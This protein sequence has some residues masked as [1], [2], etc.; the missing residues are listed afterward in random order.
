VQL[1]LGDADRDPDNFGRIFELHRI[2]QDD[3]VKRT[4]RVKVRILLPFQMSFLI[5]FEP[6]NGNSRDSVLSDILRRLRSMHDTEEEFSSN[7]TCVELICV[8]ILMF[9]LFSQRVCSCP[10]IPRT[11]GSP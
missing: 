2:V 6:Q 5:L 8:C 9:S 1:I 4:E 3:G 7:S 11:W 10:A